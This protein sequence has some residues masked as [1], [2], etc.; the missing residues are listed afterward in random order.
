MV[1]RPQVKLAI[2]VAAIAIAL[3]YLAVSGIRAGW[4]YYLP[5]DEYAARPETHGSRSRVHGVVGA[6]PDTRATEFVAVFDLVGNVRSIPVEYHG[7]IPDLFAPGREV[8][9]EGAMDERGVFVADVLLTK[10][11]SK[12]E[13]AS[14][15]PGASR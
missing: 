3:G 6:V 10:C 2:G 4:V 15:L 12:Y 7:T 11:G 14:D 8:V 13:A 5:V 9:V 1:S